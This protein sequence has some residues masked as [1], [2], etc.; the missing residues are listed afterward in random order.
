ML[1]A[2]GQVLDQ[3]DVGSMELLYDEQDYRFK[4]SFLV[5]GRTITGQMRKAEH[6]HID[7]SQFDTEQ[8]ESRAV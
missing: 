1:T 4:N 2:K 3:I 5:F 7:S 6:R 8:W